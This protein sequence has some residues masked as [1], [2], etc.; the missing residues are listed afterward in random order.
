MEE[1]VSKKMNDV[2]RQ[3]N[4]TKDETDPNRYNQRVRE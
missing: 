4:K 3:I 2:I 1:E